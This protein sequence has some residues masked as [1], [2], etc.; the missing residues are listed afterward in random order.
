MRIHCWF[1]VMLLLISLHF[2]RAV[3]QSVTIKEIKCLPDKKHYNTTEATLIYPVV[4][5]KNTA[6]KLINAFIKTAI[7]E[8]ETED[9]TVS[10]RQGLKDMAANGLINLSYEVTFNKNNILSLNIFQEG[11]GAHCSSWNTYFNFDTRT[12]KAITIEDIIS[13]NNIADFTKMVLKDKQKA[14]T[15]YKTEEKEELNSKAIDSSEYDWAIR[16]VDD[17][18][19]KSVDISNFS[20]SDTGIAIMDG[21]EFPNAIKSQSPSYNLSYLYTTL[22]VSLHP[23]LKKR[24]LPSPTPQH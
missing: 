15:L 1:I 3:A 5:T 22:S 14:L 8:K 9:S 20:L 10:T 24:L 16:E 7:V 4:S 19:F 18:C 2:Q 13:K 23:Q 12:G 11:C 21:C 6:G 17:Y